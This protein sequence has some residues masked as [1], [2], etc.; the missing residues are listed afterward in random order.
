MFEGH[1][2]IPLPPTRPKID[3]NILINQGVQGNFANSFSGFVLTNVL[4][5][6]LVWHK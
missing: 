6:F 1:W 2:I 5:L 4:I 3:F